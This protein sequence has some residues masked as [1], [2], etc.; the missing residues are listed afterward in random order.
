MTGTGS[1]L[2]EACLSSSP[3]TSISTPPSAEALLERPSPKS[4]IPSFPF[5]GLPQRLGLL[6]A[7]LAVELV[8]I[9]MW[10][11]T[12]ALVGKPGL[13]G[14][15][16]DFG[17]ATLR[18]IVAF[19]ALFVTFSYLK[20]K[21]ALPQISGQ[22]AETPIAWGLAAGHLGAMI[23]FCVLSSVL[24]AP[25]LPG[26]PV[27]ASWLVTGSLG[28][29]FAGFAL[30]PPQLCWS[31][32]RRT[33]VAWVYA[34]GGA[35]AAG[36]LVGRSRQYWEPATGLTFS[37][38]KV[39][40]HPFLRT[41]VTD[42]ATMLIGSEKFQ[43]TILTGC[44]GI[45]GVGLMLVFSV[46]WLWFFRHEWRFPRALLLIPAGVVI[47]WLLNAVRIAA[48]ILIG[49]AGA[50]GIAVGGFHSQA[51]WIAFNGVA[52]GL[53]IATR[54]WSWFRRGGATEVFDERSTTN[55][56]ALYLMPFLTILG[57]AMISRAASSEFEWLYPLRFFAAAACLWFFR[58]R[59]KSLDW[60]VGWLSPVVGVLVFGL[61][62]GL[63][64]LSGVH[65]TNAI[66]SGL[67]PWPA[68]ARLA[69][70]AI[71]TLAAVVTVPI[72]EELAFRGFL[73]RRLIS[74]DFESVAP[75]T[76]TWLSLLGSSLAFGLMHGD[77]WI[78]GMIAGLLYA[79]AFLWR[80]RI[81]D[82]V[83]AHAT[84]NGLLAVWVLVR[85]DWGLW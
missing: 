48:L 27:A 3:V 43:V 15:V 33:G 59:Y 74:S 13:A 57:A 54:Q 80:G 7:V 41:I 47:I 58:S 18:M 36:L 42:P 24:F 28:I 55:P 68:P 26:N 78:A 61:W 82:A 76:F 71:R 51:G 79:A 31:I 63:D 65:A 14:L 77:R 25:G 83:V 67:A 72:A 38:V 17:S 40:L 4:A 84:T 85:G 69:W 34:L 64:R 50:P 45:E 70:L 12:G 8:T 35:I 22:L 52:L 2:P 53:S 1:R 9:S 73:I 44:S 49:N 6:A 20:I 32:V 81:G 29:V 16:A 21:G 30:F 60:R 19:A 10:L 75:R 23:A 37:L 62:L 11:D 46:A 66:A 56:A 5:L 39:M